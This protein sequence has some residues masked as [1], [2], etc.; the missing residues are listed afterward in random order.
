MHIHDVSPVVV[1]TTIASTVIHI[2]LPDVNPISSRN[3]FGSSDSWDKKYNYYSHVSIRALNSI[4][5]NLHRNKL[6]VIL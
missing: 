3:P 6:N 2:Q 4:N 5:A 1:F